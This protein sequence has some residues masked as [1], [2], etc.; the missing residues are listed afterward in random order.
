[1]EFETVL[2]DA[3]DNSDRVK[4]EYFN[5]FATIK[6]QTKPPVTVGLTETAMFVRRLDAGISV[7]V[8]RLNSDMKQIRDQ[9]ADIRS[10][11][12]FRNYGARLNDMVEFKSEIRNSANAI[13]LLLE[14]SRRLLRECHDGQSAIFNGFAELKIEVSELRSIMVLFTERLQSLDRTIMAKVA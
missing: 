2:L 12:V 6:P 11:E 1:M 8:D 7:I 10:H 13:Q 9:L 4:Y 3:V 5:G 14:H